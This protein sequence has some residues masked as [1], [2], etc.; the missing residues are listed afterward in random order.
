MYFFSQ[1]F[2]VASLRDVTTVD[3]HNLTGDKALDTLRGVF[4]YQQFRGCQEK[5]IHSVLNGQATK[6]QLISRRL[7]VRSQFKEIL[8]A[9]EN[10]RH[11]RMENSATSDV[12]YKMSPKK[13]QLC[14]SILQMFYRIFLKVNFKY[15]F[16]V[17]KYLK[18]I[19]Y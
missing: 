14:F 18:I 6:K 15:V 10:G 2:T 7:T 9:D 13:K 16:K 3:H 5:S 1:D 19:S 12:M 8:C 4:Y 11:A 17:N